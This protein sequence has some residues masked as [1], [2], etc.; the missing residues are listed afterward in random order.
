MV[1]IDFGCVV[2]DVIFFVFG[3]WMFD[4]DDLFIVYVIIL[5]FFMLFGVLFI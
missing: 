2:M 4:F 1:I 3:F 5:G